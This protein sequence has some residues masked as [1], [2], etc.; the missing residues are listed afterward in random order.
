MGQSC[1]IVDAYDQSTA[2]SLDGRT[3]TFAVG[4]GAAFE[5]GVLVTISTEQ[6]WRYLGQVESAYLHIPDGRPRSLRGSG[7]LYRR[8]QSRD[9]QELEESYCRPGGRF[10][11]AKI[12]RAS[13]ATIQQLYAGAYGERDLR[14]LPIGRVLD[15]APTTEVAV[16]ASALL[17]HTLVCGQS[18]SGKSFALGVMLEQLLLRTQFRLVV[19][20]FNG[21][22]ARLNFLLSRELIQARG[23]HACMSQEVFHGIQQSW[24]EVAPRIL[25]LSRNG[26]RPSKEYLSLPMSMV[27]V[28][29]LAAAMGLEQGA[30]PG[31][32]NVLTQLLRTYPRQT[33]PRMLSEKLR[34]GASASALE[35]IQRMENAGILDWSVWKDVH[36]SLSEDLVHQSYQAIVLD[37]NSLP[38]RDERMVVALS[39]LDVLWTQRQTRRPTIIVTDEVHNLCRRDPSDALERLGQRYLTTLAKEGRKF[40]LSLLSA[41]QVPRSLPEDV[42]TQMASVVLMRMPSMAELEYLSGSVLDAHV[43]MVARAKSFRAGES[44]I[45]GSLVP[46]PTM[47]KFYSR[48][49]PEGR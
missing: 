32:Y 34:D 12:D 28:S 19:L 38:S 3:F 36:R 5:P 26:V 49:T 48:L 11:A 46:C 1:Q 27:P 41:T 33:H 44:L 43:E 20:D 6:G 22:F 29:V 42:L 18:G 7:R 15:A 21:D 24:R 2:S 4:L 35:L 10:T 25:I 45:A 9:L 37:L 17:R 30:S 31:A 8:F 16:S 23:P 13:D 39:V 47:C 14:P 40:L